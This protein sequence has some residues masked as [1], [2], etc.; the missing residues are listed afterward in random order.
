LQDMSGTIIGQIIHYQAG[1]NL[2][3]DI[4]WNKKILLRV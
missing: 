3:K 1:I 2:R 4:K